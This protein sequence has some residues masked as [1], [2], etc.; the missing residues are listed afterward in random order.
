[1]EKENRTVRWKGEYRSELGSRVTWDLKRYRNIYG[2]QGR[3]T[4][5]SCKKKKIILNGKIE[6][7]LFFFLSLKKSQY[8]LG[9]IEFLKVLGQCA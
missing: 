2:E 4:N 6:D 7:H 9:S 5:G 3:R 1:L 8:V